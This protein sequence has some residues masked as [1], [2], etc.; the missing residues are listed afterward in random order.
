MSN[1]AVL[2]AVESSNIPARQKSLIRRYYDKAM[3]SGSSSLARAKRHVIG[4]AQVIRQGGESAL[5]GAALGALAVELPTGLDVHV[6]SSPAIPV[7]AVVAAV[8]LGASVLLA[9]ENVSDDLRNAGAAAATVFAY[10][11]SHDYFAAKAVAKGITPG[12]AV[13]AAATAASAGASSAS[14]A[15]IAHGDFGNDSI[16]QLA[17]SLG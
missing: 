8:G 9:H 3:G 10:R 11:K 7:D 14:P 6:G 15:A 17:R 4:G 2:G 12:S 16:V 1:L 5:V 13:H